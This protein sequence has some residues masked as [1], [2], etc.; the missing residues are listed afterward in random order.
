MREVKITKNTILN[1]YVT[2]YISINNFKCFY[3]FLLGSFQSKKI[4]KVR[5]IILFCSFPKYIRVVNNTTES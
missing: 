4:Y 3:D 5:Y 2:T 1:C